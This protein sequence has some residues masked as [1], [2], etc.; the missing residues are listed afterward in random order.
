MSRKVITPEDAAVE[1]AKR[2]LAQRHLM[3]YATYLLPWYR[4]GRHHHLVGGYLE[5]VFRYIETEGAEGIGRL[6]IFEPPRHGK[7]EQVSRIFPSWLLG[8]LPDS[9][10]MV[11]S[12]GADLAAD[13]SRAIRTYLT[14]E[15]YRNVF[16]DRSSVDAA[17]ELSEDSRARAQWNLAEPHRGGVVSAGVGGGIVGKGAHLLIIDDPF[18]GRDEAA[19]EAYRKRAMTW[20]RGSAYTRLE[21]GGA[22]VITHTRWDPDDLAGQLLKEMAASAEEGGELVDRWTV[23][24]LPALALDEE[25]YPQSDEEEQE[26]LLRGICIP[27]EDLLGRQPGEPLWPEKYSRE[28]LEKIRRNQMQFEFDAQYQQLPRPESG[29]FFD[30][31]DFDIVDHIPAGLRWYVYADL[32]LGRTERSDFNAAAA[33]ALDETSGVLYIRDLLR[34]RE[35]TEFQNRLATWMCQPEERG[36]V[37]GIEDVQ[38]QSLAMREFFR[39]PRLVNVPIMPVRPDA[40]KV[41]RARSLQT[42]GRLGLVKV[43]RGAWTTEFIREALLFP[44]GKN[45]DQVDTVTGGLQMIAEMAVGDHKP[46]AAPARAVSADQFF[47]EVRA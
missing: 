31:A 13:D 24:Y 7:T 9:R 35:L 14:S 34:V 37:W 32:A 16:G 36:T 40:D 41:T 22:I 30:E 20:Y 18:K 46:A 1:R 2:V 28:A 38:F 15:R 5:Q 11:T 8:K 44:D 29:G 33:V 21:K 47:A 27:R 23:L 10:I 26:N 3:D 17:V 45:D 4:P 42:R 6:M 43:K 19:S 12:Y 39:D 25:R